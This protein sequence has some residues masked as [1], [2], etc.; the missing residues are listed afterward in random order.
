MKL[1]KLKFPNKVFT[2]R[3]FTH[4]VVILS[5]LSLI[6]FLFHLDFEAMFFF[7]LVVYLMTNFS[8]T[9]WVVY[10]VPLILVNVYYYYK[11]GYL[12]KEGL[13][14]RDASGNRV[15]ASGNKISRKHQRSST[16]QGLPITPLDNSSGT[17]S[18]DESFEVGRK[19][20]GYKIDYASTVEDAY[21]NLNSVL[22]SDGIKRLTTDTQSLMKQQ[23]QLAEAM[24]SMG[25][26]IQG[27]TP[28]LKQA[29]GLMGSMGGSDNLKS[30]S[31][32]AKKFTASGNVNQ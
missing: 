4:I 25:P 11:H 12:V 19:K 5:I 20:G 16:D 21:D 18:N 23:L 28:L 2:E 15:D 32:L 29:E 10:V 3:L 7:G 22:G 8:K 1:P 24:K 6:N 30:I 27:M 14:N 13:V 31:N 17:S 9:L 26:L